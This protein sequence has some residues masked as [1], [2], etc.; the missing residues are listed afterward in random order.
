[1]KAMHASSGLVERLRQTVPDMVERIDSS[2][3]DEDAFALKVALVQVGVASSCRK[4]LDN[5]DQRLKRRP[6]R[7]HADFKGEVRHRDN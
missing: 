7:P 6:A 4:P 1:M 2:D 5:C 3:M